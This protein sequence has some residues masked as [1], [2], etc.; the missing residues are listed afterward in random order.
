MA[1]AGGQLMCEWC[2][3]PIT[4]GNFD[5]VRTD[6]YKN[7]VCIKSEVIRLHNNNNDGHSGMP[8]SDHFFR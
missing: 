4:D 8:C 5:E 7:G 3:K 6:T 1:A 2:N